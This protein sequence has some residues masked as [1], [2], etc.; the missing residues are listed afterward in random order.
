MFLSEV[1]VIDGNFTKGEIIADVTFDDN[2]SKSK[3][4]HHGPT[5]M[6]EVK[7]DT[8]NPFR[9]TLPDLLARKQHRKK[10]ARHVQR[11]RCCEAGNLAGKH[12]LSCDISRDY[13]VFFFNLTTRTRQKFS[14]TLG[15]PGNIRSRFRSPRSYHI[16]R[17]ITKC[18]KLQLKRPV[19]KC[20]LAYVAKERSWRRGW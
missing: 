5:K 10:L 4:K 20:C 16:Y 3:R 6:V 18:I 8:I 17:K 15:T 12:G 19:Q 13:N 14:S 1:F 11:R 2:A 9:K 7:F